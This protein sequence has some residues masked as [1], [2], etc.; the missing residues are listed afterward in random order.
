MK[1]QK[2]FFIDLIGKKFAYEIIGFFFWV[3]AM[4][5]VRKYFLMYLYNFVDKYEIFI[6]KFIRF[7]LLERKYFYKLCSFIFYKLK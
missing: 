3:R 6:L 1:W 7:D 2:N 5:E 4:Y